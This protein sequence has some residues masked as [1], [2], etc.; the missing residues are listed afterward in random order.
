MSDITIEQAKSMISDL[1][2][3]NKSYYEKNKSLISDEEY[4]KLFTAVKE[5]ETKYP[6]LIPEDCP[7]KMV[8]CSVSEKIKL[9]IRM[10]SLDNTNTREGLEKFFRKFISI[11]REFP[12]LYSGEF[13]VD[14]KLDGLAL[15]LTYLNGKLS[16]AITRGDGISGENVLANAMT[17]PNIPKRIPIKGSVIVRGE[18]VVHKADFYAINYIREK[19][20]LEPFATTRNYAAGSLRQKDPT[21]TKERNLR[22]YAF[23]LIRH[24][25]PS[26]QDD[27]MN[28]LITLGFS[29]P[30]GKLCY[31]EEECFSFINEIARNRNDLAYDIDGAVV[32]QNDCPVRKI[33]GW[34]SRAPKWAI[35]WKYLPNGAITTIKKITW[36]VG[37]TGRLTP[38]AELEPVNVNG[39]NIS[40]VTLFNAEYVVSK[41]IGTGAKIR[42]VRSG[43]VIPKIGEIISNGIFEGTPSICPSCGSDIVRVGSDILCTNHNCRDRKIASLTHITGKEVLDIKGIGSAFIKSLLNSNLVTGLADLFTPID[44]TGTDISQ[45]LADRLVGRMRNINFMELLLILGIPNMGRA[46]AGRLATEIKDIEDF[47]QIFSDQERIRFLPVNGSVKNNLVRWFEDSVNKETLDKIQALKLP[48][49]R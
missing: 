40:E 36:R 7:T 10:Y 18:V 15:S 20:N 2:R 11:E 24:S 43:D 39:V 31:S 49:C 1:I 3:Y 48:Q 23:E 46:V 21:V 33:V 16:A 47:K 44:T 30:V 19:E 27:Q 5:L 29:I 9:P 8:G 38:V 6:E 45:E 26:T 12:E 17:I 28:E 41:N 25:G 42:V 32:K 4:D 37:K 13:Y 14:A 22:F 35:A 34:S